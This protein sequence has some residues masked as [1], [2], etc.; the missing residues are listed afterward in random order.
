MLR[1]FTPHRIHPGQGGQKS[2]EAQFDEVAIEIDGVSMKMTRRGSTDVPA[3]VTS[4]IPRVEI[5][6]RTYENGQLRTE[7]ELIVN[8]VTIV[9]APR[10]P[11]AGES[12]P[13]K[14]EAPEA[15]DSAVGDEPAVGA[16]P[17]VLKIPARAGQSAPHSPGIDII[18]PEV[19]VRGG[20]NNKVFQSVD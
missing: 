1:F 18:T 11:L 14:G 8:S 19:V 5:R 4:V 15:D 6:K 12:G 17:E 20:R 10:H 2:K 7:E 16:R 3:E 9:H 13:E